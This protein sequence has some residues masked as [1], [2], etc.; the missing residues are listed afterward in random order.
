MQSPLVPEPEATAPIGAN[1]GYAFGQLARALTTS[2]SH[3]NAGVRARAVRKVAAWTQVFQGMLSGVLRIGSRT[4]VPRTPTWATLEVVTG[5]FATG[6]LLAGGPLQLHE[7][8]M[9]AR[10][11]NVEPGT[12]RAA[13]NAYFLSEDG[14][15]EL[16]RMLANGCY[17]VNVPE[18]G[19]LLA[20]AW[21]VSHDRVD[22]ARKI[23]DAIGAHFTQLR[24]YPIPDT[25]PQTTGTVVHL[26]NVGATV[27]QLEAVE[28]SART[29]QQKE[30]VLVWQ[31]LYDRVVALFA[32]TVEG[33]LPTLHRELD[34]KYRVEGGWPC[35]H[36]PTGWTERAKEVLNDYRTLRATH[37]LCK[38]PDSPKDG[39]ATLRTHLAQCVNDP[40]RLTGRDVGR[41]RT[42]LAGIVSRRGA[43]GSE[44]ERERRAF[45]ARQVAAP[46]RHELARVLVK[47]LAEFPAS[48]GLPTLDAVLAP[49]TE[50]ESQQFGVPVGAGVSEPLARKVRRALDAPLP[51]LMAEGIIP[52]AEALARV[53]PQLTSQIRAAG[54][55]DPELRRLYVDIYTAFR[56]R[57]SLL[58]LNLQSQV[59]L[60][61]LPWVRAID[62]LRTNTADTQ[63]QARLALEE[64][65][66]AALTGFPQQILPNK[67]LQEVR[68]LVESAGLKVPIVDEIA[69]DIFMGTFSEKFLQ[70]AQIAAGVLEGTLYER[71]YGVPFA[72][73]RA[74]DDVKPSRWGAPTSPGFVALCTELAGPSGSGSFVARN[75]TIIE[76]EQI[77]TTHNLA[78]LFQELELAGVLRPRCLEL[79][80]RV[81]D[82][83]CRCARQTTG[84]WKSRLR[85]V[86][87]AAY[88]WRQIVFFLT[89]AS[90]GAVNSFLAQARSRLERE[91]ENVR[92]RLEPVLTGLAR[93]ERGAPVEAPASPEEP[94]GARRLL[95]WTSGPHWFLK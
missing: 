64:L 36:Y 30:A 10:L 7:H 15:A 31:P 45:H 34:G 66:A 22:D 21:L 5:G 53:V 51:V 26:Q 71:Y 73:V 32:E 8:R 42:I 27:A 79:A 92:V 61:E 77:L 69:A 88:A 82:G 4:P 46:G 35:Q 86:K 54:I 19:A 38:S 23:L 58:L 68:A 70:A 67:L 43:P 52:S 85:A 95:G 63:R 55:S 90:E 2:Q 13:L 24:F 94:H 17:R 81:F 41:I 84:P 62:R 25:R 83:I 3:A 12:E 74:L 47:R 29:E 11:P 48:E 93:A 78:P 80:L 60:E 91:P 72:R 39:F 20:V 6:K 76:Q 49:F 57:R 56:R 40:R 33:P 14:L 87:N 1:S 50:S 37:H 18:E 89:V 16:R 59:K 9:L 65:I 28:P 75:G 44:R